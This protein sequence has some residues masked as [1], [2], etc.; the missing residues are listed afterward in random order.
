GSRSHLNRFI[1]HP[2]CAGAVR[3]KL[4]RANL[5]D[6]LVLLNSGQ[7]YDFGTRSKSPDAPYQFFSEDDRERHIQSSL[8]DKRYDHERFNFAPGIALDRLVHHARQRLWSIQQRKGYTPPFSLYLE[9]ADRKTRFQM[10]LDRE[11]IVEQ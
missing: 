7:S 1:S 6:R 5:A 2:S 11:E 4:A 9:I 10:R 8:L 3:E